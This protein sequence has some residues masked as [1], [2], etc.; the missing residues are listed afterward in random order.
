MLFVR[1]LIRSAVKEL[2]VDLPFV[3]LEV[4]RE[5]R[6]GDLSTPVSMVL[7]KA[8]KM[9]PRKIAEEIARKLEGEDCFES[10]EIAGPGFLNLRF[11]GS[12][13]W[14]E[15]SRLIREGAAYLTPQVSEKRR[16]QVEFVSANPT[17]PLHLGHG[18]GA[19]VGAALS[20]LLQK[21][22]YEVERE[23]YINDA[24]RQVRLLGESI[25]AR[26][27]EALGEDYPFP[28]D[29]YRGDY[30]VELAGR[31]A[32]EQAGKYSG[33]S[34]EEA[35]EYFIE[36]GIQEMLS[37]I[38]TDLE[39]FGVVFD[40]WQSERALYSEELVKRCLEELR[41]AGKIYE[42]DGALWFRASEFGDDKDRVV[43]KSDGT[44][45]YFASD[46]AYH[47]YKIQRGF[48]ELIDIWGA[49]HHGYIPRMKAVIRALGE[50][51]EK[52]TVMLVQMVSLLRDGKPV[53]MSKRSGEF[54]T[55]REVMEEVGPD[56]TKFIFL[57]RKPESHLEFDIEVAKRESS[58]NPVFYVQYAHARIQSIFRKAEEEGIEQTK[59][60]E[61]LTSLDKPEEFRLIK[62]LLLYPLVF[63]GAV[64]AREPHRITFYLQE[65]AGL[66]HP[67]YNAY[68]V[69]G[70]EREITLAR[71][72]LLRAVET[73][74]KEGLSVLGIHAPERM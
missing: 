18:R 54:V 20:N 19:A 32:D 63:E 74:L 64:R 56:T 16:V 40:R 17:G 51:D 25:F 5:E 62:K 33:L 65:L 8:L 26:Y 67:Y 12:F 31:I 39:D 69:L 48:D 58:E 24:G 70:E 15:L 43:I 34:F 36:R 35:G 21:A 71:L 27:K 55:L 41:T 50:D 68:R 38:K 23:F 4:P 37:L 46:I 13:L 10:V 3:E 45:T 22:G 30:I 66:F 60:A 61:G 11:K 9:P 7:A 57:T 72:S 73:V 53:Q 52:L 1:E 6:F 47:W 28:E 29:G 2:G 49:D 59:P 42:K 44:H 14:D